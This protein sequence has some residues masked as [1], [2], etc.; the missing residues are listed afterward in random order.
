L[1]TTIDTLRAVLRQ[2][3]HHEDA[4]A[5]RWVDDVLDRH[6]TR[7]MRELSLVLPREQKTALSTTPGSREVS[8]V[9]LTDLV[10]IE[11]VEY[12]TSEWPPCYAQF[13]LFE[14]TLT[15]L[16][17]GA[18]AGVESLNVFWGSLH[19]LD[20]VTSTLPAPAE[21][22]V[23]TGAAAYAALEWASFATNRANVAGAEA[24]ESYRD[25]GNER[26]RQFHKA[27]RG[28][29]RAAR[30]RPS[31]LYTPERPAARDTVQWQA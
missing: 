16:V 4:G 11:A 30:L 22:T 1:T 31:S 29:G 2:E 5:Y 17:A 20:A 23:V 24:F 25:W 9:T 21:D 10:R 28:F 7:A 13:A 27:L 14:T 15:L 19:T 8:I 18:P 6:L 12:P 3:L 26:L